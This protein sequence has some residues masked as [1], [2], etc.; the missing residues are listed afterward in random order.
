[1]FD[2]CTFMYIYIHIYIYIFNYLV[3]MV[4]PNDVRPLCV[5]REYDLILYQWSM[6]DYPQC[7]GKIYIIVIYIVHKDKMHTA[8]KVIQQY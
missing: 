4:R 8:N 6:T 7:F 5:N 2:I 1:M 3:S